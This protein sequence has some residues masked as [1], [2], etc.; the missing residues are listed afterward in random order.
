MA[1]RQTARAIMAE[2]YTR[3]TNL[4]YVTIAAIMTI[5]NCYLTRNYTAIPALAIY[6]GNSGAY[7]ELLEIIN[8]TIPEP[9]DDTEYLPF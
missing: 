3:R 5:I 8:Q 2:L 4:R 1:D 6:N 7:C 9:P